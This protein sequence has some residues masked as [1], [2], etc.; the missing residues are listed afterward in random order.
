MPGTF[1]RRLR[2]Q[3]APDRTSA[4]RSRCIAK[5][6]DLTPGAL[7]AVLHR[8]HPGMAIVAVYEREPVLGGNHPL[9]RLPNA[10]CT[11]RLGYVERASYEEQFSDIAG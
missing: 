11:P 1:A 8:G 3:L 2:R 10:V 6:D 7:E 4:D 9:S 5:V